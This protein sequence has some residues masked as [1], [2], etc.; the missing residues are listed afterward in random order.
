MIQTFALSKLWYV[1]Q[2]LP[3]PNPVLKK[4]DSRIS[5]FVFQ[6]RPERLKLSE[7]E[8]SPENGGLGLT[9]LA[10]KAESLLL[11]Q[12]LRVLSRPEE[13]CSRH[14]GFWLGS[15][16]QQAF[17]H[18]A[19]LG[20]S[21]PSL[22]LQFPLHTA[23]LEVLEEGL[24]REEFNPKKLE[25]ATT[26]LIYKSRINDVL[27][28]PKVEEKFPT[29]DFQQLVYPRLS[30]RILEPESKD[31]LFCI[32]HGLVHNKDR[33][34][35]QRRVQDP[36][37]LLPECQGKVQ[38]LEHLFCSCYLVNEAWAWLRSKLLENL[39]A[40]PAALALSYT[41]L[42]VLKLEFPADILDQECTWLLGNYCRIVAS[43]VTGRKKILGA[44][45]LAGRGRGCLQRLRG[46]AVVQPQLFKFF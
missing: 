18:L 33:M 19:Q 26:K 3:L 14:M 29:V 34:F 6:G 40:T 1:A 9:C 20:P 7:I 23:I 25:E 36:Y 4:I 8:N 12:S 17:P 45:G 43:T 13:S 2:L 24:I 16:L 11:R 31:I 39:P 15:F 22:Y 5:A 30:Y 41:N 38:D 37:C 28:P 21:V 35:H 42:E 10:T 46:R 27:L 32:V 44:E